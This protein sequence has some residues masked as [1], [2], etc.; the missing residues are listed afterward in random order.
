M[1]RRL[2]AAKKLISGL[3]R[4]Q[5]RWTEDQLIFDDKK[6]KLL[7]DCLLCASFMSYVGPFDFSFRK[8]MIYESWYKDLE[9]R[10][11]PFSNGFRLEE[12][13]T[14]DVEISQW[15]SEG[16][17]SDELSVQNGKFCI[18]FMD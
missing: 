3:G 7:G 9:S 15:A 17:P 12:L 4:E 13:L 6:Y 2:N 16:L 11:I 14:S 5:K 1:E 8:K 18:K 10:I